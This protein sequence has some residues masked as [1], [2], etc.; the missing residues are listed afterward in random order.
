MKSCLLVG[1][2]TNV[3][4]HLVCL[5]VGGFPAVILASFHR[6]LLDSCLKVGIEITMKWVGIGMR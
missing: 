4:L 2:K 1:M 6:S 3:M 5:S